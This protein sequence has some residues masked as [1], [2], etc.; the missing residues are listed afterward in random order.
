[1]FRIRIRMNILKCIWNNIRVHKSYFNAHIWILNETGIRHIIAEI[2]KRKK[3]LLPASYKTRRLY[4]T[5]DTHDIEKRQN[6]RVFIVYD[7]GR[8][9]NFGR[10]HTRVLWRDDRRTGGHLRPLSANN[11]SALTQFVQL[12]KRTIHDRK[13]CV[14]GKCVGRK[15]RHAR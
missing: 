15:S 9:L 5:A 7:G 14:V 12:S 4:R 8:G 11:L 3:K 10:Y 13:R 2:P 1:M 6:A